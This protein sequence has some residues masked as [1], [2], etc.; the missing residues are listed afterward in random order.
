MTS[1]GIRIRA[2]V[3]MNS[4]DRLPVVKP[5]S[6]GW[7]PTIYFK[8]NLYSGRVLECKSPIEPGECGEAVVA[9]MASQPETL[10]LREG[11]VFELRDGPKTVIAIATV[12]S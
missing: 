2:S 1:C 7:G 10:N 9:M 12:L 5:L 6:A 11:C 8:G 4:A 3:R